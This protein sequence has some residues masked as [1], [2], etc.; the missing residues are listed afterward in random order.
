MDPDTRSRPRL[1]W[2][3]PVALLA[4]VLALIG[5]IG[6]GDEA[7]VDL[8]TDDLGAA[9]E[10]AVVEPAAASPE[11]TVAQA[12]TPAGASEPEAA[13]VDA[14][15][16][17]VSNGDDDIEP[18]APASAVAS[19]MAFASFGSVSSAS[20]SHRLEIAIG[21]SPSKISESPTIPHPMT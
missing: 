13:T 12:S 2:W 21:S 3:L 15:S 11:T 9:A 6:L 17:A 16:A 20:D 4:P 8:Y 10:V 19:A 7:P 1:P 5:F 18:T 14:E